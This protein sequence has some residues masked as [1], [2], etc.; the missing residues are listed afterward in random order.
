MTEALSQPIGTVGSE[1]Q[2]SVNRADGTDAKRICSPRGWCPGA[3]RKSG[4]MRFRDMNPSLTDS[5]T[6]SNNGAN[7]IT[8]L[9]LE[10]L[11]NYRFVCLLLSL[12]AITAC[13]ESPDL[14]RSRP[15]IVRPVEQRPALTTAPTITPV[16]LAI[17]LACREM[18]LKV[19]LHDATDEASRV[20]IAREIE[21][22][23]VQRQ[24][25]Y[26]SLC[27]CSKKG[28]EP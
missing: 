24:S 27:Q 16:K 4:E 22:V 17:E 3:L 20:A 12:A 10:V 28:Q 9:A 5:V 6:F 14:P 19:H 11:M 23:R 13:Q 18:E 26:Q 25:L 15:T 7:T 8:P 1:E 2:T 21:S